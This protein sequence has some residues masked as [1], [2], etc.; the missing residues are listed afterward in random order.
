VPDA[1]GSAVTRDR[2]LKETNAFFKWGYQTPREAANA[3]RGGSLPEKGIY[4][5]GPPSSPSSSTVLG[6]S[7]TQGP[8]IQRIAIMDAI[9]YVQ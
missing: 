1:T 7:L 4:A 8:V 9:G 3:S 5:T 2:L 6:Y